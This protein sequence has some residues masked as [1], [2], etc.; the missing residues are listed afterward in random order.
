MAKTNSFCME[1]LDIYVKFIFLV[2]IRRISYYWMIY[3]GHMYSYLMSSS[4][5]KL[6]LNVSVFVESFNNFKVGYSFFTIIT[7]YCHLFSVFWISS[8]RQVNF[9]FVFR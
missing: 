3:M 2:S 9:T 5:F 8:Y 4:C 6:K 1:K 7:H